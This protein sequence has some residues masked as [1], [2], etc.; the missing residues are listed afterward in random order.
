MVKIHQRAQLL[1]CAHVY[2]HFHPKRMFRQR[3]TVTA[4]IKLDI[5]QVLT[6]SLLVLV[7]PSDELLHIVT[8]DR[9][10]LD[11]QTELTMKVLWLVRKGFYWA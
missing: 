6:N 10:W 11:R 5:S 7:S 8:S 2:F 9:R 4:G 3:N 1:I